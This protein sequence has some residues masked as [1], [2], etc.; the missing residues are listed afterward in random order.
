MLSMCRPNAQMAKTKKKSSA[1]DQL[2]VTGDQPVKRRQLASDQKAV[3]VL[4]QA[5]G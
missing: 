2:S 4:K 3:Y 5:A 1:S